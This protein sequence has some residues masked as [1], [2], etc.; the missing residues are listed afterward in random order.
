MPDERRPKETARDTLVPR[1]RVRRAPN[2]VAFLL[3]G[4]VIGVIVGAVIAAVGADSATSNY[5]HST[6]IGF[7]AVIFGALGVLVAAVVALI[8]EKV[9]TR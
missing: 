2:L 5:S 9:M 7:F 6:S 1:R 4:G 8:I 3:T